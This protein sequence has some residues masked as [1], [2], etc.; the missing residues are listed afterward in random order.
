MASPPAPS[1]EPSRKRPRLGS[2]RDARSPSFAHSDSQN[3]TGRSM[4]A[5]RALSV[6][7]QPGELDRHFLGSQERPST[8]PNNSPSKQTPVTINIRTPQQ[9]LNGKALSDEDRQDSHVTLLKQDNQEP[10]SSSSDMYKTTN[11][12]PPSPS[13]SS[14]P[15]IEIEIGDPEDLDDDP[16]PVEIHIDG[17]EDDLTQSLLSRFPYAGDLQSPIDGAKLYFAHLDHDNVDMDALEQLRDWLDSQHQT[18]LGRKSDWKEMYYYNH[19]LWDMIGK[20][21]HKLFTRISISFLNKSNREVEIWLPRL[22]HAF[23]L[24][25]DRLLQ[26]DTYVL[27]TR[28]VEEVIKETPL[29]SRYLRALTSFLWDKRSLL[30][31]AMVSDFGFEDATVRTHIVNTFTHTGGMQHISQYVQALVQRLPHDPS[32]GTKMIPSLS[33]AGMMAQCGCIF[34]CASPQWPATLVEI[35][36][37]VNKPLSE[38][39]D[40]TLDPLAADKRREIVDCLNRIIYYAAKLDGGAIT[41]DLFAKIVGRPTADL[42]D[43]YAELISMVWRVKLMKN[44]FTKGRMDLRIQGVDQLQ[45]GLVEFFSQHKSSS[46]MDT[47]AEVVPP[48]LKCLADILLEEK[49]IE[50]LVGVESHPQLI[51]RSS[52]IVGFLVVTNKFSADQADVVWKTILTSQDPRVVSATLYMLQNIIRTLTKFKEDVYLCKKLMESPLPAMSPEAHAFFLDFLAIIR[53]RYENHSGSLESNLLPPRLCIR[54]IREL[55]PTKSRSSTLSGGVYMEA[56]TA[57]SQLTQLMPPEE[58]KMLYQDCIEALQE[59]S[60]QAAASV[61]AIQHI[62]KDC[63]GDPTYLASELDIVPVLMD[64]FCIFVRNTRAASPST[65]RTRF[66]EELVPRLDLILELI[67][68]EPKVIHEDRTRI[69][70]DHLVGEEASNTEA[71]DI[72]WRRLASFAQFQH[73][74]NPFLDRCYADFLPSNNPDHFTHGFFEFVQNI[75]KYKMQAEI[76]ASANVDGSH[77]FGMDLVWRVILTAHPNTGE[78]NAMQFLAGV[79]LDKSLVQRM[80]TESIDA[81]HVSLVDGCLERLQV[82]HARLRMPKTPDMCDAAETAQSDTDRP[83]QDLVFQRTITFLTLFLLAIR[84]RPDF[85]TRALEH[86]A[87]VPKSTPKIRGDPITVKYQIMKSGGPSL[88]HKEMIVGELDTRKEFHGRIVQIA[89]AHGMSSFRLLWSGNHLNLKLKPMET[90]GDMGLGKIPLIIREPP[91][92]DS[93]ADPVPAPRSPRTAFENQIVARF[94]EFYD[95]MDADDAISKAAFDF[96]NHFPPDPKVSDLVQ[97][98]SAS[99]TCIFPAG[100]IFKIS[101]SLRCLQELLQNHID[102][103]TL[104]PNFIEHGVHLIESLLAAITL[105]KDEIHSRRTLHLVNAT[106]NGLSAFLKESTYTGSSPFSE[107]ALLV[108][109]LLLILEV[110]IS[111]GRANQLICDSYE[112]ILD[113]VL[114]CRRAWQIFLESSGLEELHCKLLLDNPNQGVRNTIWQAFKLKLERFSTDMHMSKPEFANFIWEFITKL[115]PRVIDLPEQCAEFFELALYLLENNIMEVE[116]GSFTEYLAA[117]SPFIRQHVHTEIIGKEEPDHVLKG[118]ASLLRRVA[119]R[120]SHSQKL[121]PGEVTDQLLEDV[122]SKYLFPRHLSDTENP[123]S[124]NEQMPVVERSTRYEIYALAYNLG[125]VSENSLC[126]LT[127]LAALPLPEDCFNT[128]TIDRTSLLRSTAGYVGLRNL[129]NTCYMNSLLTQLYMNPEFRAFMLNCALPT[130]MDSKLLIETKKLFAYMQNGYAKSADA[131]A[132]TCNIRTLDDEAIDIR[133]QMDVDEF[134]NTLF[135]RWE[136]Q[137]PSNEAKQGL[138]SFYTGTT[139]QQIKSNECGHVSERVDTCLAIQCDVQGKANLAESLQAFVEGDVMEGDNKYK[140]EPCGRLVNAVKRTCLKAVP[141]HLIFQLK[142]FEYDLS[143]QRRSKINEFFEFPMSIDMSSYTFGHLEDPSKPV[144]PDMFDLVGVVV[145]KGQADHGHYVSYIRVRPS[146]ATEKPL[147]LQFDD[148]DVTQFDP[149]DIAEHCYGGLHNG[150]DGGPMGFSQSPKSFNGYMLFYQRSST[151]GAC[152]WSPS[153][154]SKRKDHVLVPDQLQDMVARQNS[155][156]LETYN[157][158]SVPHQQFIHEIKIKLR[159]SDHQE[160]QHRVQG[161]MINLILSHMAHITCRIKEQPEF[162]ETINILRKIC[163][164]CSSCCYLILKW[165]AN[166]S[167]ELR[168]FLLKTTQPRVRQHFRTFTFDALLKLKRTPKLY[169]IEKTQIPTKLSEKTLIS[170]LIT[171]LSLLAK[172]ELHHNPRAWDDFW[173]LL[174]DIAHLGHQECWTMIDQGL[175]TTCLELFMIQCDRDAQRNFSRVYEMFRRKIP[176]HNHLVEVVA[177]LFGNIDFKREIPCEHPEQRLSRAE[178]DGW[179]WLLPLTTKE[180]SFLTDWNGV[181]ENLMWIS[182]VFDKWDSSREGPG[183]ADFFPGEIV[184]HLTRGE[185]PNIKF[186]LQTFKSNIQTLE[187]GFAEPYLRATCQFC[188]YCPERNLVSQMVGFM[189]SISAHANPTNDN[190][191]YNGSWCLAFYQALYDITSRDQNEFVG[192]DWCLYQLIDGVSLWAPALL[193]FERNFNVGADTHALL[194]IAL[195]K[196]YTGE[197]LE[198]LEETLVKP[199]AIAIRKLFRA[200]AKRARYLLENYPSKTMLKSIMGT[201]KDCRDYLKK[202]MQEDD[203]KELRDDGDVDFVDQFDVFKNAFDALPVH[204]QDE[205][206]PSSEF[207]M[208][209]EDMDPA[210]DPYE[211]SDGIS[212]EDDLAGP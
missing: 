2:S 146:S 185:P 25:V 143:T 68:L 29:A 136:D 186:L 42:K 19:T 67:L 7:N 157:L 20:C 165:I 58:R 210:D 66:Q 140:C 148:A 79:Y 209:W 28:P 179:N 10:K 38:N 169:G 52:N 109:N 121:P 27:S 135:M 48:A 89:A 193:T 131:T 196:P 195:F 112:L 170:G 24:L 17:V 212:S 13:P 163:L 63:H 134:S 45:T 128:Y 123:S 190:D 60:M 22:L 61:Q 120:M 4:S 74:P 57:L 65:Q 59:D 102:Q 113:C 88:A 151:L 85:Q 83:N 99:S 26:V 11:G 77:I 8:P 180:M 98:S 154:N 201:M 194:K 181:E 204:Q 153:P 21:F 55:S 73:D 84:K 107:P 33:I 3:R 101:Y 141:N 206:A 205:L 82:A 6:A 147:W 53:T 155:E 40:K 91:H 171:T 111:S 76:S 126:R 150:K 176:P 51:T 168:N 39:L 203:K 80:S 175:L 35:F 110:A 167:Q 178:N 96:L 32:L 56:M 174:A 87:T 172:D 106:V 114:H 133:E 115:L 191:G 182:S 105:A 199:R 47:R 64:E 119:Q 116:E 129:G 202:V 184:R 177:L 158:F 46:Y 183:T 156:L 72:S 37:V 142:R 173:G 9:K 50:F 5:D 162:E 16:A 71:R 86:F 149:K 81:A 188:Q 70:W 164:N 36:R 144:V 200:C 132:F 198:E 69:F 90:L 104:E 122:W 138:K 95:L 34:E 14:S 78:E 93:L 92:P 117:W 44:Y 130:T 187:S 23:I 49:I 100:E 125:C 211:A 139:V 1:S 94:D 43:S 161:D 192:I 18:L 12:A 127:E 137:M 103:D 41:E 108:N 31:C 145:H 30:P 124:L 208:D 159:E 152:S 15:E 118:F 189:N 160:S 197:I 207:L 97:N 166:H 75:T 54:L 62:M